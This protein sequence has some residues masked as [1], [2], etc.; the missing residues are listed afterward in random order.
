MGRFDSLLI[1]FLRPGLHPIDLLWNLCS[2]N[3]CIRAHENGV[4]IMG[5]HGTQKLLVDYR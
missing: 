3:R 1:K 4:C 5:N 2:L